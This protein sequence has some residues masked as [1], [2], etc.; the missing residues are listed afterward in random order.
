MFLIFE[1]KSEKPLGSNGINNKAD[2]KRLA[3][4]RA[5]IFIALVIERPAHTFLPKSIRECE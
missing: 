4:K 2:D 1:R 3:K 5:R